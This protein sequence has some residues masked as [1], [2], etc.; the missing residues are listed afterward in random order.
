MNLLDF[1]IRLSDLISSN[2]FG[3]WISV[4]VIVQDIPDKYVDKLLESLGGL[5]ESSPH[6]QFYLQWC[7]E[8]LTLHGPAL[9]MRSKSVVASC[10]ALQKA[11]TQRHDKLRKM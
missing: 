10:T 11:L 4:A 5:M 3:P 2:P 1:I 8:I 9:K 7:L 6:V